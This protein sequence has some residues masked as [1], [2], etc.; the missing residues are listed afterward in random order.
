MTID[1]KSETLKIKNQVR[2]GCVITH[3]YY[4]QGG[5][6]NFLD[7]IYPESFAEIEGNPADVIIDLWK[8]KPMKSN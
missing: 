3:T 2:E 1:R 8:Q 5:V 6:E 7:G 4:V